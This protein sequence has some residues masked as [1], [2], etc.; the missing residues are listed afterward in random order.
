MLLIRA[1]S[2]K[3][4]KPRLK[5]TCT[6]FHEIT[7]TKVISHQCLYEQSVWVLNPIITIDINFTRHK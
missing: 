3:L 6:H 4:I 7:R 2:D 5:T 1:D